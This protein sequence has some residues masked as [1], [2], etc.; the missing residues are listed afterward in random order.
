MKRDPHALDVFHA[1]VGDLDYPMFIVTVCADGERAGCLVGFAS[2]VSIDPARF[3][4]CPSEKNRTYRVARGATEVAVHLVPADAEALAGLFGGET[5]DA[6][7]KFARVGWRPGPDGIPLLDDCPNRFIG[8][9]VE[10]VDAGDHEALLLEPL[11]AEQGTSAEDFSFHRA[12]R[13]DA[14]HAA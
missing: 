10:R 13:I 6:V 2:Q 14:G 1:L 3:M 12:R 4:V 7:D 5:G 9:I 11:W 8:G